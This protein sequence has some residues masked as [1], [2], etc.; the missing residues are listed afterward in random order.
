MNDGLNFFTTS[1][2]YQ[3]IFSMFG[4]NI[5]KTW[6]WEYVNVGQINFSQVTLYFDD[7][8]E[9]LTALLLQ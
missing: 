5:A 3:R 8:N 9:F 6:D 4:E 2:H 7:E 1:D